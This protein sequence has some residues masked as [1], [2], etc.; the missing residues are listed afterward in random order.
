M[1][2]RRMFPL[3]AIALPLLLGCTR[4]GE[5]APPEVLRRS[6]QR[7]STLTSVRFEAQAELEYRRPGA[8]AD[9]RASIRGSMAQG[10]QQAEFSGA[11]DG[12]LMRD[13]TR[14]TLHAEGDMITEYQRDVYVVLRALDIT[15]LPEIL[16]GVT[17]V[18][19]T[20]W[21][22]GVGDSR[23]RAIPQQVTPDPLLLRAQAESITVTKDDGL[24]TVRGRDAYHYA[25][26]I[27]P[28][29]LQTF[30]QKAVRERGSAMG[31]AAEDVRRYDVRGEVWIDAQTFDLVR[32]RWDVHDERSGLTVRILAAFTDHDRAPPIVPPSQSTLVPRGRLLELLLSIPAML[33]LSP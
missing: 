31:V 8:E 16:A 28:D 13:E 18:L 2:L 21:N 9:A 33:P 25:V 5:L 27:D 24:V 22:V 14:H 15:P 10:G 12:S 30:V 26:R 11:V 17:G 3:A 1:F 20:W 23:P 7:S 4:V 29:T 32:L 19:G 6:V